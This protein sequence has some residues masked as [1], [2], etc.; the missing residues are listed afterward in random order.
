MCGKPAACSPLAPPPARLPPSTRPPR[1]NRPAACPA[2]CYALA[3]T[4]AAM[5]VQT[6]RGARYSATPGSRRSF[7]PSC[8]ARPF[9]PPGR[10]VPRYKPG[11][12][13]CAKTVLEVAVLLLGA[14]ISLQTI[15]AA[16]RLAAAGHCR[17]RRRRP[18]LQLR[19]R[20]RARAA[21]AD[22]DPGGGRQLHL[23]QLRYR[24]RGAGHRRQQ[25]GRRLLHRLHRRAW[26]SASCCCCRSPSRCCT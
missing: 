17:H 16:G 25:Q 22:G 19:H 21:A 12:T 13:F 2:S 3:V 8:S 9:A 11:V 24:R 14:S 1:R 23:R 15:A 7:W 20:S 18:R 26:V 5:L 4:V 6:P 10:P